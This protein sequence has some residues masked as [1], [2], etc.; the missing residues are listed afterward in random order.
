MPEKI[1]SRYTSLSQRLGTIT[2]WIFLLRPVVEACLEMLFW[3][4]YRIRAHG[5]GARLI[6]TSGPLLIVCNHSARLR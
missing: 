1:I 2:S 4:M 6:P 5:P 3:P